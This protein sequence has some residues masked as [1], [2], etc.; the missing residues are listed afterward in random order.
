MHAFQQQLTVEIE[1]WREMI[2]RQETPFPP[3]SLERMKQALALAERK[4]LLLQPPYVS[5][6][7]ENDAEADTANIEMTF[8]SDRRH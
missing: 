7:G 3:E 4:L 2:E 1:F 8:G 6:P 5:A